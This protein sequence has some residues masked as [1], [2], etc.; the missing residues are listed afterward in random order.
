[1]RYRPGLPLALKQINV[2]IQT[3]EK[4]G[5][6]GRTGAGKSSLFKVLLRLI[7][8]CLNED[9]N[10][11]HDYVSPSICIDGKD[12]CTLSLHELRSN[13]GVIPQSAVLLT[14]SVRYN[15][16]PFQQSDDEEIWNVLDIVGLKEKVEHMK[17]GL[18]SVIS[19]S[20]GLS[21]NCC[22]LHVR[23]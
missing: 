14:E 10:D 4:I 12:I 17:N 1:M 18:Q 16:D 23:C 2:S 22:A 9:E 13:I 7:E 3:G 21:L 8:P 6:V 11:D 20:S 15:L 5:I 19:E